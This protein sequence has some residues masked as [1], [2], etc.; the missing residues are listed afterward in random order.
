[1][2]LKTKYALRGASCV[3]MGIYIAAL[4]YFCFFSEAYGR[5]I[6]SEYYRYNLRPFHEI[7]R[8]FVYRNVVGF[9]A[10]AMNLFGNILIFMPFGCLLPAIS[11][12]RRKLIS[13][14]SNAFFLSLIIETAQLLSKV[15]SFD[16]D[17]LILNT[18]GGMLG[19]V[20]FLIA[21]RLRLHLIKRS[22]GGNGS[23][24]TCSDR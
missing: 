21:D 17:D 23:G 22:S 10:F 1:M 24:R 11:V 6:I 12:K 19:Y 7:Y 16:V 2:S 14:V 4:I 15:G 13:V 8:F 9:R 5:N 20:V 3:L 18:F